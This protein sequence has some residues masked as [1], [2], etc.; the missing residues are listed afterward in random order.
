MDITCFFGAR[1]GFQYRSE[2][3]QV[4]R[5][6]LLAMAG[7]SDAY[8]RYRG[9]GL[10]NTWFTPCLGPRT[11]PLTE[12]SLLYCPPLKIVTIHLLFSENKSAFTK[13]VASAW[14]AFKYALNPEEQATK[15]VALLRS[16]RPDF[17]KRC[18]ISLSVL[19]L[20]RSQSTS[21]PP[22]LS[23]LN[24][25]TLPALASSISQ[26]PRLSKTCLASRF[27]GCKLIAS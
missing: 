18:V 14:A 2:M 23:T 13:G 11:G 25:P 20:S 17:T 5:V 26:S 24:I 9:A 8:H 15:L 16:R 3:Q 21:T 6:V 1:G 27:H 4:M 10:L 19:L 7:Y 22:S 12:L